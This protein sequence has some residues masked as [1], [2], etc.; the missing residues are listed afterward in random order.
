MERQLNQNAK[1]GHI[2][3]KRVL[4]WLAFKN[5]INPGFI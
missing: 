2:D 5:I 1:G 4:I 3:Q